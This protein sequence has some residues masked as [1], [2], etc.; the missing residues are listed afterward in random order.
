MPRILLRLL[1]CISVILNGSGY[2]VAATQMELAQRAAHAAETASVPPC[3]EGADAA[4]VPASD[5]MTTPSKATPD[6][7]GEGTDCCQSALCSCDCLQHA[8][9]AIAVAVIP[10]GLQ[11][12]R[13]TASPRETRPA[14]R[15]FHVPLRPPIA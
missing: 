5:G 11:P 13:Y 14:A 8:T 15:P 3:H 9:V 4:A 10:S 1:L 7:H 2:A 6:P 12:A